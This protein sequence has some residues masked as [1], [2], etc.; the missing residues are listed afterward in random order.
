MFENLLKTTLL[1]LILL[2]MLSGCAT[3]SHEPPMV[4]KCKVVS[5][6]AASPCT[7][8]YDPVCG[9]DGKTYGNACMANAAGVPSATPG[10]CEQD[11]N[12]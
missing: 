1:A 6:E 11:T 4:E 12:N 5:P 3:S 8:Q 9:C 2:T 10:A 7:M